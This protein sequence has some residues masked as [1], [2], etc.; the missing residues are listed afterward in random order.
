MKITKTPSKFTETLAAVS[1]YIYCLHQIVIVITELISVGALNGL[2]F[3]S[4]LLVVLITYAL[5]IGFYFV[6][7]KVHSLKKQ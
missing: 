5:S 6:K 2:Y 4:Y 1:L 3:L 7:R